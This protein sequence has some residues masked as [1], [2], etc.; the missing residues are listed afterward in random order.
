MVYYNKHTCRLKALWDGKV[1]VDVALE[2]IQEYSR[3]HKSNRDSIKVWK[4]PKAKTFITV[5]PF[6]TIFFG[7]KKDITVMNVLV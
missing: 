1:A 4:T 2:S 6:L 7:L 3:S 5:I